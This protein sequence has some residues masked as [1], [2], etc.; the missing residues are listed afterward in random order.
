MEQ[1]EG[2]EDLSLLGG[3]LHRMGCPLGLVRNRTNT[4]GLGGRQT[5]NAAAIDEHAKKDGWTVVS[6]KDD[7]RALLRWLL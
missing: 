2:I 3:P 1:H 5:I 4:T 6:M 7:W